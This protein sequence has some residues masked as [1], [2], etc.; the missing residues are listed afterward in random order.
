MRQTIVTCDDA[1]P[2]AQVS[3]STRQLHIQSTG[4]LADLT[5]RVQPISD[6]LAGTV[7]GRAEDLVRIAGYVYSADQLVS[8][9][10]RADVAGDDWRRAFAMYVP[11][12]E[13]DFWGSPE[14]R[15]LLQDTLRQHLRN[16]R[17][18]QPEATGQF[19]V[20]LRS[21]LVDKRLPFARY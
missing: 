13:P 9:G 15:T 18:G 5:L 6:S 4:N 1:T 20:G 7:S 16:A 2:P 14:V 21:A 17:P 12:S 10:G 3:P 19:S 8:R 11:V